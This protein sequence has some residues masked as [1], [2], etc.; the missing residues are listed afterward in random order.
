VQNSYAMYHQN[1]LLRE[2]AGG[3]FGA[4]L[5]GI[6][7]DPAMLRY[8]DN[9]RNVKGQP[10]ENLAREIM[11][12]FSMGVNQ[13]YS[14]AD[15]VQAARALT[16]YTFD[17]VGAFR[18]VQNAHDTGDKKIFGQAGP[19]NGDDVVRLILA[20]PATSRFVATRLWEFFAYDEPDGA[21]VDRLANVLR[22]HNYEIEPA[23]KNLFL[24]AEFYGDRAVGTQ[25]KCPVQLAIGTLRDLGVKK[26]AN[27]GALEGALREMGQDVF[28]P[29][30][31]KGWRYGRGWIS[32]AR[33][34]T[35]YNAVAD[36][37]RAAHQPQR[38][39]IDLVSYL[40]AGGPQAAAHPAAYLAKAC[41]VS[42]PSPERLK[43]FADL[44]RDLPPPDQWQSQKEAV[45]EK[46]HELL[47][48]LLST[49]E[50]QFN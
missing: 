1:Q 22:H 24:S 6:V 19:W 4:L 21:T 23:L 37:V 13:G 11:E 42:A 49:P 35:R 47:I 14:E 2:N 34:Y 20:Q 29:P 50:Y 38:S 30:D 40:Q 46:L 48:A 18:V 16:G 12:L 32:T 45:N 10:N 43:A 41:Y 26:L 33:L 17:G 3:N 36:L 27:Y 5:Y 28:E 25:I 8:L 31:V 7:H 39:G 9:N 44:E 15:I